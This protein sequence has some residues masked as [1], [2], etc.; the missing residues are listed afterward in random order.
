[1]SDELSNLIV[2]SSL[3]VLILFSGAT[4]LAFVVKWIQGARSRRQDAQILEALGKLPGLPTLEFLRDHE[5]PTARVA[6]AGVKAWEE[7]HGPG[8][9]PATIKV[10]K[11][12]LDLALQRRIED[13][14]HITERGLAILASV[15]TTSPFIGLFGTVWGI[16]HALKEISEAGNAS[17]EVVAG[18]IG[19]A[20]IAT[21]IGIAVAVP[22]VL[23]YNYFV[24]K[25]KV[26]AADLEDF[27]N[28]FVSAALEETLANARP[29]I[30]SGRQVTESPA[31]LRELTV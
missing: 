9:T 21:G 14:R 15:G 26:Q 29:P 25:L 17:L 23:I 11:Q 20:L 1:M 7:N 30:P 24:R 31:A 19:E 22:A 13:E 8:A 3:G 2:Q 12:I 4:W 27:A 6:L 5:G 18:P 28:S 16:L 10:P